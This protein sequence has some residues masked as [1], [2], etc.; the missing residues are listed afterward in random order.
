MKLDFFKKFFKRIEYSDI[1]YQ[2]T[3][4]NVTLTI[5]KDSLHNP[6]YGFTLTDSKTTKK[7]YTCYDLLLFKKKAMKDICWYLTTHKKQNFYIHCDCYTELLELS[8]LDDNL[9]ITIWD[10]YF[11]KY[12]L[13]R[14]PF[15]SEMVLSLKQA[16]ELGVELKEML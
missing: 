6:L 9:Y 15:K 1:L 2:Y 14:K 16:E 5:T 12:I 7:K 11:Y 8:V 3:A 10:N 13:G 4:D